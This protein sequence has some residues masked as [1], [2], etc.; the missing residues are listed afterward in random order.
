VLKNRWVST[1]I[2]NL[3][4]RLYYTSHHTWAEN[5][6][7]GYPIWQCPLDLQLYQEIVVRERPG[8][9]LQ[10]GVKYGGSILYFA[11]LL[12]LIGAD[13]SALVVGIDIELSEKAKTLSNPRIRL[14]EGS[15][16]DPE[17][18]AKVRSILPAKRGM[19][20][21]DSDHKEKHVFE[22]MSLYRDLVGRDHYLVV[23]DTNINGHPVN[24]D[25]GRGPFEAV[26]RF[27]AE[28]PDFTRDDRVWERNMFSFHQRGW[29]KRAVA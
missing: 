19:V 6:F 4:H 10:T 8:F 21:L 5:T 13:P 23:E 1:S 2:V 22:E 15:S 18:V 27:L 24:K 25:H 17:V 9:I 11:T 16:T 14:I 7:L 26:D 3:F 12:D 20:V 28:N 29:L